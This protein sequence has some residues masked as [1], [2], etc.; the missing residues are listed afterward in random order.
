MP[1]VPLIKDVR[2]SVCPSSQY[3]RLWLSDSRLHH[4]TTKNNASTYEHYTQKIPLRLQDSSKQLRLVRTL[5]RLA[6]RG[7]IWMRLVNRCRKRGGGGQVWSVL[8]GK[9]ST[10]LFGVYYCFVAENYRGRSLLADFSV[11]P[12]CKMEKNLSLPETRRAKE[13]IRAN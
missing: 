7:H 1:D 2:M 4:P 13:K 8:D 10:N 11:K 5:L 3:H 12:T 9:E 6:T